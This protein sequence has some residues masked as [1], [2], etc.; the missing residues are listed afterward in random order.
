MKARFPEGGD[1]NKIEV[2]SASGK[3]Y[4]NVAGETLDNVSTTEVQKENIVSMETATYNK[5]EKT[6]TI[7]FDNGNQLAN[8]TIYGCNF[9]IKIGD[10]EYRLRG[11]SVRDAN[12]NISFCE[13]EL[14][15]LGVD[16]G[17]AEKIEIRYAPIKTEIGQF[18]HGYLRCQSGK[19]LEETGYMDVTVK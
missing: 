15:H 11:D 8:E 17:I 16:L 12:N 7:A 2:K 1:L 10:K 6:L 5:A 13:D 9:V 3:I 4:K 18:G 19:P 14:K